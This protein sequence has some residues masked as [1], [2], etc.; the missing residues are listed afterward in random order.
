MSVSDMSQES[1]TLKKESVVLGKDSLEG[2]Y[3]FA[4][5]GGSVTVG[6]SEIA[7]AYISTP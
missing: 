1:V 5:S 2:S 6:N 4:F 3:T 7:N